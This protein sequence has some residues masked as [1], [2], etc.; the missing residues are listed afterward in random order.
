LAQHRLSFDTGAK[1]N[2]DTVDIDKNDNMTCNNEILILKNL[3]TLA[4]KIV[5]DTLTMK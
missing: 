5:S 3:K 2:H 4:L 1:R